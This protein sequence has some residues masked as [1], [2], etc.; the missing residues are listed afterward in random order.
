MA[1]A[2]VQGF[3]DITGVRLRVGA[4]TIQ[5]YKA[6]IGVLLAAG[7]ALNVGVGSNSGALPLDK[8]RILADVM[9][10]VGVSARVTRDKGYP[11]VWQ[12]RV[13]WETLGLRAEAELVED[14]EEEG[15]GAEQG[16]AFNAE[17][18]QADEEIRAEVEEETQKVAEEEEEGFAVFLTKVKLYTYGNG[19]FYTFVDGRKTKGKETELELYRYVVSL[20]GLDDPGKWGDRVK[21][22][23]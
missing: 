12:K 9:S 7:Q 18:V 5:A 23:E 22:R 8:R 17:E 20:E 15:D 11:S 4:V 10:S 14:E 13:N 16:D 6:Q 21:Q 19:K 1:C 3:E 2:D